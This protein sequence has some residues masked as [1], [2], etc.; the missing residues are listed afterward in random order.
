M[1]HRADMWRGH[2]SGLGQSKGVGVPM[3][4]ISLQRVNTYY[5][6]GYGATILKVAG[7]HRDYGLESAPSQL[8]TL[9]R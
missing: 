5:E 1:V 9:R 3:R 2:H 7:R 6:C 8:R 4:Q